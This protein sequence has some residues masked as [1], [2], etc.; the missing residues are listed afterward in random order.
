MSRE[1]HP[2]STAADRPAAV[3]VGVQLQGV[4]GD[5]L[6]SSLDELERLTETLGLRVIGRVTQKRGGLGSANLLGEGKLREL[7]KYTGGPGFVPP[8]VVPGSHGASET[9]EV[10]EYEAEE[11]E[12]G[13]TTPQAVTVIVDHDLSPTQLR[14]LEKV[15]SVEVLDRSMVILSIFQRHARTR[16]AKLQVEIARLVYMVPRLREANAGADRQRGGIGGKGAGESALELGRRAARDRIAALRR[17][18]VGVQ[19]EAETQ[20]SRRSGNQT[21]AVALIGYTNAGKSR[22]MRGLTNETLYVA[23]QL[24]ATLDTTVRVLVP[25]T[26]PRILISDTVGFIKNLPHDLVASFRSTLAEAEEANLHLHVIDASDPAMRDQYQVT[27]EVLA[28]IGADEHPRLLILNKCDLLDAEQK[29]ALA[30]EFPE[31]IL[32]AAS[33]PEDVLRLHGLIRDFFESSMEEETFVI[34]YDEQAKVGLL[35]EHCRVLEE[36]YEEDGAHLRVL[37]P[38]EVL[39]GLRR[40]V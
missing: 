10:E 35:Y 12:D 38:S 7:A 6:A 21:Q 11:E 25:E 15:T 36:L 29:N 14:N 16:E 4:S 24:F 27:R 32:M 17:T 13:D 40:E 1:S 28:E 37:A 5:E 30:S 23:D 31:A 22:L 26:R 18:L 34:P 9:E 2:S 20:R 39:K 8:F 19:K 33:I 3:L